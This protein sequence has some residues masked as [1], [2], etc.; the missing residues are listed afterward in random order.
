MITDDLK[1]AKSEVHYGL[2]T[3]IIP[4]G[5]NLVYHTEMMLRNVFTDVI[6]SEYSNIDISKSET[7]Y[8]MIP[9]LLF[10]E[11]ATGPWLWS[12]AKAAIAME[13][14]MIKRS[15]EKVWIETITGTYVDKMGGTKEAIKQAYTD[16]LRKSQEQMLSSK[17]LRNLQ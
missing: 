9:K 10:A 1:Q 12:P 5:E 13:W 16:L 15:G 4:M 3:I 2:D 8:I 7:S 14:K 11:N 6:I 17:I